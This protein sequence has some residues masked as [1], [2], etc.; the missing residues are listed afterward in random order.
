M[1]PEMPSTMLGHE[2]PPRRARPHHHGQP[3][4]G[5]ARG[6]SDAARST[7]GPDTDTGGAAIVADA[8]PY[9]GYT[10]THTCRDTVC[11]CFEFGLTIDRTHWFSD[12]GTLTL[13]ERHC[14]TCT[15]A[16]P[17]AG[18]ASDLGS[19]TNPDSDPAT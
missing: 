2:R 6:R 10:T 4:A 13:P 19:A 16:A 3:G 7:A 9:W 18:A 14:D 17:D 1:L 11:H 5:D 15:C 12:P 8:G